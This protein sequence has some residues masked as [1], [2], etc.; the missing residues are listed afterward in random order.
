MPLPE[1]R[2]QQTRR[3]LAK[4]SA[5]FPPAGHCR[6]AS[7]TG[8]TR[9][10]AASRRRIDDRLAGQ[11]RAREREPDDVLGDAAFGVHFGRRVAG[12]LLEQLQSVLEAA[13]YREL[14]HVEVLDDR[15]RTA[16]VPAGASPPALGSV[17]VCGWP[18]GMKRTI[19]IGIR[20]ARVSPSITVV[21]S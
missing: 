7:C 1:Q 6:A 5:G 10:C 11:E 14:E 9:C 19:C 3:W 16:A 13:R 15:S 20:Q 12:E 17:S 21:T 18:G 8:P 4:V 2:L